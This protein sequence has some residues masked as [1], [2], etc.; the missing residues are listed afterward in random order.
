MSPSK[1]VDKEVTHGVDDR[2]EAVGEDTENMTPYRGATFSDVVRVQGF[3]KVESKPGE[4]ADNKDNHDEECDDKVID[5]PSC[6]AAGEDFVEDFD[7]QK[8]KQ[9]EWYNSQRKKSEIF[10][11]HCKYNYF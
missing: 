6:V 5:V 8:S 7:I 10:T 4:V 2:Q 9:Q 11:L 1:D 3:V